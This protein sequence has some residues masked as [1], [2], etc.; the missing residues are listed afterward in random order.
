MHKLVK[1]Q[2]AYLEGN[3]EKYLIIEVIQRCF[4]FVI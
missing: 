4:E 1:C 3:I 2:Y